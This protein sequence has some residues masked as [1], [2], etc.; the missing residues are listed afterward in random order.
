MTNTER[1]NELAA[2]TD[3][4]LEGRPMSASTTTR[5]LERVIIQ[6]RDVIDP[7]TPPDPGYSM[8]LSG[9]LGQEFDLLQRPKVRKWPN[10]RMVQLVGM[11][12]ALIVV[13]GIGILYSG[14]DDGSRLPGTGDG[15]LSLVAI[16]VLAVVAVGLG[17]AVLLLMKRRR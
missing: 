8:R 10:Q 12:A 1:D 15:P 16:V 11:A 3:A 7:D 6:L 9:R 4:V 17:S 2:L 5:D 14:G 13:L